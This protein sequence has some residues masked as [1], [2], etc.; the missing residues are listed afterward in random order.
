MIIT[1][2]DAVKKVAD[3][4]VKHK[5]APRDTRP[6]LVR[7]FTD[8]LLDAGVSNVNLQTWTMKMPALMM[9]SGPQ[10][11]GILEVL[12]EYIL[13][14]D[15][16]A[17][18]SE[19]YP[20]KNAEREH[21]DQDRRHKLE[22]SLILDGEGDSDERMRGAT[23]EDSF[24]SADPVRDELFGGADQLSAEELTKKLRA[25]KNDPEQFIRKHGR[26]TVQMLRLLDLSRV[27]QCEMCGNG[28]YAHDRRQVVC[29]LMPHPHHKS[30]SFCQ[31]ERDKEL[32][33]ER[34]KTIEEKSRKVA[35]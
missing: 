22:T 21:R 9:K 18:R 31:Y 15:Q 8:K 13:D 35:S 28:F 24:N 16:V 4:V 27:R 23:Y 3:F 19:E 26:G 5:D 11:F 2:G 1:K 17:E 10:Q 20:I 6:E 32:A 7:K 25:I 33:R 14:I 30:M 12:A 34:K 29:N